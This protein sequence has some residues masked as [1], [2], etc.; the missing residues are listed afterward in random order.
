MFSYGLTRE[1]KDYLVATPSSA[2]SLDLVPV[3]SLG[4]KDRKD[5]KFVVKAARPGTQGGR[6]ILLRV[7]LGERVAVMQ[8]RAPEKA[9]MD[10][11]WRAP[12]NSS[13]RAVFERHNK[14]VMRT[15][16][17]A[18]PGKAWAQG[19][20]G[21]AE[22]PVENLQEHYI[23]YAFRPDY[24]RVLKDAGVETDARTKKTK[25]LTEWSAIE[26]EASRAAF[27]T[28]LTENTG[29]EER[30]KS[31]LKLASDGPF[32][33]FFLK[34]FTKGAPAADKGQELEQ[35]EIERFNEATGKFEPVD[36]ATFNADMTCAANGT[37]RPVKMK[38]VL[39]HKHVFSSSS[40][41]SLSDKWQADYIRYVPAGPAE[42]MPA[43]EM[44]E[45]ERALIAASAKKPREQAEEEPA[46][47]RS[48]V[49]EP[50]KS[51]QPPAVHEPLPAAAA[52]ADDAGATESPS[53]EEAGG[54]GDD[55]GTAISE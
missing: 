39:S 30:V 11:N 54:D 34:N 5:P 33:T 46:A 15:L 4:G 50:P 28:F 25:P 49:A 8:R 23:K 1:G 24:P 52:A 3:H 17:E 6:P 29:D 45:E 16:T 19:A 2:V 55:D 37:A 40:M 18:E 48:R 44:D 41:S 36:A 47:K 9:D 14:L 21:L 20:K 12:L 42:S 38:L 51:E 10:L 7:D 32:V 35:T 53:G 43:P 27:E 22:L 13:T 26:K 31:R